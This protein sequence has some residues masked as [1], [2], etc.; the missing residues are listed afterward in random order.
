M[1]QAWKTGD[2]SAL[3]ETDH[4]ILQAAEEVLSQEITDGMSVYE[5]ELAIHDWITGW[6]SFDMSAFSR[7]PGG[8]SATSDTPY[9]VLLQ[10][11]GNCWGYASTFQLF[12]ELLDIECIIVYGLPNGSGVQHVWNMV[13]L[14]GEWY[15]VD[16]AWDDPIGGGPTHTYFN[17]TSEFLRRGSIHRWDQ[18]AVPEAAGTAYAYSSR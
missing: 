12:M 6:S 3:S 4:S 2:A 8:G 7:A 5:K 17:V 13:R 11:S 9:G 1:V 14:D 16:A 15:C 10:R 18:A